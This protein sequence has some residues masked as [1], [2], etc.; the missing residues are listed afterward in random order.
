MASKTNFTAMT[1]YHN[2][3]QSDQSKPFLWKCHPSKLAAGKDGVTYPDQSCR[4]CKDTGHLIGNCLSFKLEKSS[5]QIKKNKGG[6]KLKAPASQGPGCKGRAKIDHFC[7]YHLM[8]GLSL[9]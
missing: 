6:V 2:M 7:S 3:Q 5:L 8:R 4:Y 9:C 1:R